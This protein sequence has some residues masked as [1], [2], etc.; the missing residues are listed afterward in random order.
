MKRE[1]LEDRAFYWVMQPG[2][3]WAVAEWSM[4]LFWYTGSEMSYAFEELE[5]CEI[6]GP[7]ELPKEKT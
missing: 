2:G 1:E 3:F 7:I 6:V 5:E 4:G